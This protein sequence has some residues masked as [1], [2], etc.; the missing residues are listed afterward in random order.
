MSA[1]F[2]RSQS[3]KLSLR[4]RAAIAA[5]QGFCANPEFSELPVER[6]AEWSVSQADALIAELEE[7]D[8][9]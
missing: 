4:E 6:I 2:G 1:K 3:S 7:E 9:E 8:A 5:M